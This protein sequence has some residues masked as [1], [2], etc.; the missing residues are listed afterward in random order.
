MVFNSYHNITSPLTSSQTT[1][2][3][4][5]MSQHGIEKTQTDGSNRYRE[6]TSKQGMALHPLHHDSFIDAMLQIILQQISF[7]VS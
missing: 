1:I 7:S 3:S 2:G 6:G 4:G 5:L